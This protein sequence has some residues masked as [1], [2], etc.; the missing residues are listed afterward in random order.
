MKHYAKLLYKPGFIKSTIKTVYKIKEDDPQM[1][2]SVHKGLTI[3]VIEVIL[4]N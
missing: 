3:E 1:G 2:L 4:Q